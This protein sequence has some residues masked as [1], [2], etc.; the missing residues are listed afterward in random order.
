[1]LESLEA[2]LS[3]THQLYETTQRDW[4]VSTLELKQQLEAR[5]AAAR[6][7]SPSPLPVGPT[8]TDQAATVCLHL[9][10][11]LCQAHYYTS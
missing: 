9:L 4:A 2:S 7:P 3:S 6:S 1:M 8:S 5:A 11:L 10:I